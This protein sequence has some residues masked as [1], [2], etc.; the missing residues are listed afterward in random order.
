M[1][2]YF[3]KAWLWSGVFALSIL[4][5]LG[6]VRMRALALETAPC[7]FAQGICEFDPRTQHPGSMFIEEQ[8][9]PLVVQYIKD[10]T[11][12]YGTF[13]PTATSPVVSITPTWVKAVGFR[14]DWQVIVDVWVEI[15]YMGGNTQKEQFEFM[16]N[17]YSIFEDLES[18]T[19]HVKFGPLQECAQHNSG[20]WYCGVWGGFSGLRRK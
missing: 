6:L 2:H 5:V 13:P 20:T 1:K 9:E 4:G 12:R 16:G 11:K 15:Y 19:M 17:G 18:S 3:G 10:Q 8:P 14:S 7:S